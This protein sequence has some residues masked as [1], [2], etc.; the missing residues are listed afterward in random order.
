MAIKLKQVTDN[1]KKLSADERAL[2]AR[3]LKSSLEKR[4]DENV[5]EAWAGVAER[6]CTEFVSGDVEPLCWEE[7]NKE[8]K[9]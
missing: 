6:C 1:I 2:V 9:G 3:C 4:Q 8:V 7:V 5:G